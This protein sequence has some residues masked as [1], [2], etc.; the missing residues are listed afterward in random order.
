MNYLAY[1]TKEAWSGKARDL[2]PVPKTIKGQANKCHELAEGALCWHEG[3]HT[4][5]HITV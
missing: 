3:K 5:G 2:D 1:A 4:T